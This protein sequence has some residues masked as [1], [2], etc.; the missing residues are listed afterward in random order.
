MEIFKSICMLFAGIAVFLLGMKLMG[1]GLEK[2]AGKSVKKIFASIGDNRFLGVL[3]GT[4]TT[5][6]IQS[7]SAT[8]VMVVGF[9]NA[10]VM[11][12]FQAASIIMGANIGTTVTAYLGVLG[13]LPIAYVFMA[14][15]IAGVFIFMFS[16]NKRMKCAGEII[17]GLAMIFI[18][19]NL[20][21]S[22]FKNSKDLSGAFENLFINLS[23][24]PAGPLLLVLLGA[25]FTGIIQSSS[26]TTVMIV[27]MTFRGL[28]PVEAALFIV[29]GAN[30]GTC[31]TAL[32][33]SIGTSTNAKRAALIHLTF[34]F[35]GTLI[36]IPIIWPLKSQITNL[37]G[38]IFPGNAGLQVAIFHTTFNFITTLVLLAFIKQLCW[39]AT[40]ILSDKKSEESGELKLYFINENILT[41]AGTDV[42]HKKL[43]KTNVVLET[44]SVE[45]TAEAPLEA[46]LPDINLIYKE[47]LNMAELAKENIKTALRAA[48]VPDDSQRDK[49]FITEQKINYINKGIGRHLVKLSK[50]KRFDSL[51]DILDSF[52]SVISDIERIG[53]YAI[54]LMDEVTEM[55]EQ[56]VKFSDMAV[57]EL[58]QMYDMVA[59]LYKES[60][61]IFLS[62]N[63]QKLS[64]ITKFEQDIDEKKHILGFSHV[65]RLN[66][67]QCS[68]ES[69]A[70]FYIIIAGLERVAN[71]FVNIA[72]SIEK[73]GVI[74]LETLRQMSKAKTKG[75]SPQKDI[76]W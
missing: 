23:T 42:K 28:I 27:D 38:N 47:I 49:V 67:E 58:E 4:G 19:M 22:A 15:G 37:L 17:T 1:E 74:R 73:A 75:K 51:R 61:D 64:K 63:V 7:S 76:Y 18:G 60:M 52:H 40:K 57:Q 14:S 36:F 26:A 62:R 70:H 30:I 12:L 24:N 56:K 34:N 39:F 10:G 9:V 43:I 3:I 66:A 25:V 53:D 71:H 59:K 6:V 65:A 72:F 13:E 20:M 55:K 8:T 69:G 45:N 33:A 68:I 29:M 5:S 54:E 41:P 21:G 32:L 16:K 48:F 35:I 11:T 44:S 31:V 2:G 46:P 50:D